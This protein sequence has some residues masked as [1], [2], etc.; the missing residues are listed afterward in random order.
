MLSFRRSS[1]DERLRRRAL[2]KLYKVFLRKDSSEARGLRLLRG[3]LSPEQ[4]AQFNEK[5]Y[6]DVVGG[7]TGK[8]YRIH[9][10]T[11]T[12]VVELDGAGRQV[13]G[14]CFLPLGDLVAGD[15]MLAQKIALETDEK[16]AL[17]VAKSFLLPPDFR[18][19]L[20]A[21][22]PE[23]PAERRPGPFETWVGWH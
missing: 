20:T 7:H 8:R 21:R 16:A 2:R 1:A 17:A 9:Y 5:N 15:I 19:F 10:G 18:R 12:N 23:A 14:L 13:V 11:N 4:R 6:F 3:W 22:R